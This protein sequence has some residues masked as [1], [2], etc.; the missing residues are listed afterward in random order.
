V[1]E[2]NNFS[3]SDYT[4]TKDETARDIA[5]RLNLAESLIEEK[6]GIGQDKISKGKTIKIPNVYAKKVIFYVDKTSFLPVVQFVYD[7][8]GLYEQYE[9]TDVVVNPSF[10]NDEFSENFKDYKFH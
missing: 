6:N 7:D 8:K 4:L 5:Q 2:Y 1:M 3:Y 10:A 9:Y